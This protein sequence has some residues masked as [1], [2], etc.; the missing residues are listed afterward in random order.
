LATSTFSASNPTGTYTVTIP[1]RD[2][3]YGAYG[4]IIDNHAHGASGGAQGTDSVLTVGNATPYINAGDITLNN[5][6]SLTLTN[7]AGQTTGFTLQFSASDNNSCDTST[8]SDEIVGNAVS[9]FRT[10]VGTSSCDIVG[11]YNANNC[12]TSTIPQASWNL[13]CTAS[14]T[15]CTG[16]TDTN[17]IFNCTFPLWYIADPTDGGATNTPQFATN[18]SAAIAPRDD[19]GAQAVLTRGSIGQE[20]LSFLAVALDTAAIPYGELEPGDRTDPLVATTTLR[21]T[22]NVG[23]D[24]LLTGEAMCGTYTSAVTCPNSA[25]STIPESYQVY[26]TSTVTYGSA[27]SA[28]RTLSSTT[29]KE[30]EINVFKPTSTSTQ[31]SG[32]TYWGIEVPIS[33]TLAGSYTGENT[34]YGRV[35]E[36]AQWQ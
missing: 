11:E 19:D 24:Q 14:T 32:V 8:S 33:I 34:F 20:L 27:T 2:T 28:L 6:A 22:G 21:A 12:Y 9:V 31:T 17:M 1:T 25:T 23:I 7:P 16:P 26:A 5:G 4:F 30:L 13:S 18:W 3:N 36:P 29:Q 35:N 10:N 15:S